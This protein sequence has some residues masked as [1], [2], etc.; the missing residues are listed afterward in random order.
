[1]RGFKYVAP[2]IG[3]VLIFSFA[4]PAQAALTENQIQAILNLLNSFGAE[5][6]V[7]SNVNS[8]LRGLPVSNA[9]GTTTSSSDSF[10]TIARQLNRTLYEGLSDS[11]S[12]GQVTLIQRLLATDPSVY[13]EGSVTG[14]FGPA[15]ERAVQRWQAKFNIVK[16]GTA[17]TTGYGVV[18]SQTRA[19]ILHRCDNATVDNSTSVTPPADN[20]STLRAQ[21]QRSIASIELSLFEELVTFVQR[22]RSS[23]ANI[24]KSKAFESERGARITWI[25]DTLK[26]YVQKDLMLL[27][28][29][30][31]KSIVDTLWLLSNDRN[32][33]LA[34]YNAIPASELTL[35]ASGTTP[36]G[37]SLTGTLVLSHNGVT[38]STITGLTK[39]LAASMCGFFQ[40]Y[41]S[42]STP[43][44][45][46][47][48][49]GEN[50]GWIAIG[51]KDGTP[52]IK[53]VKPT[54]SA[55]ET[56][57]VG[58]SYNLQFV[59]ETLTSSDSIYGRYRAYAVAYD[60]S[61][62]ILKPYEL[63]ITAVSSSGST[64]YLTWN[65]GTNAGTIP[66]GSYYFRVINLKN[67]LQ[68]TPSNY[69]F[70]VSPTPPP[71]PTGQ[72][73]SNQQ[74][75][76]ISLLTSFG[77]NQTILTRASDAMNGATVGLSGS[78]VLTE[79]QV[80]SIMSLVTSFGASSS[81]KTNLENAIRGGGTSVL[82]TPTVS[83]TSNTY[84]ISPGQSATLS[85][86]STNAQRCVLSHKYGTDTVATNGSLVV[87]PAETQ[88]YML[89]CYNDSGTG[90]DGPSA[91][92]SVVVAVIAGSSASTGAI[93]TGQYEGSYPPGVYHDFYNSPE[94]TVYVNVT[95]DQ[96]DN[97]DLILTSYEPVNWIVSVPA[98]VKI[99]KIIAMG[100]HA[101]RVTGAPA[102]TTVE[103]Y[104][105]AS[106]GAYYFIYRDGSGNTQGTVSQL[107]SWL[108]ARYQNNGND[109]FILN[110]STYSGSTISIYVGYKG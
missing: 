94:G 90:K 98:G 72:L 20:L 64:I 63:T 57:T 41:A 68:G 28:D 10:C 35:L 89:T 21:A 48:W 71:T 104:S 55:N 3:A 86:T 97:R 91:S 44:S 51:Q 5:S 34:A 30:E 14:Y 8:S 11:G 50:L 79:S 19:A 106:S 75:S 110:P 83:L 81:I 96:G 6:S 16:S 2:I 76:I 22:V 102:G 99:G 4:V 49:N 61:S 84:A 54:V 43:S 80:Q 70:I 31:L 12:G 101:Q 59:D 33:I 39:D 74:Q 26:G 18:G 103:T 108:R 52:T 36:S 100:Y 60:A 13:P 56:I 109:N 7:V 92:A 69:T 62:N 46:C 67:G 82:L 78:M 17:E 85:W 105:L 58:T 88:T 15:T 25:R 29:K 45:N 23:S 53:F 93:A 87:G 1:M 9:G 107:Q 77:A 95:G 40:P 27:N 38:F 32:N 73:N 37:T 47:K 66:A 24:P 42:A 65:F